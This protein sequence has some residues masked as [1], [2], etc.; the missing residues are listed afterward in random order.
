MQPQRDGGRAIPA[1]DLRVCKA[2]NP[3]YLKDRAPDEE[4]DLDP[5]LASASLLE[6]GR[7]PPEWPGDER[8]SGARL[9]FSVGLPASAS[10]F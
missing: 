6:G 10:A 1:A 3:L 8:A 9:V 4:S 7:G 2:R 5:P